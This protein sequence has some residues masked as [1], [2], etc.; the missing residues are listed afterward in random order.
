MTENS[1]DECSIVASLALKRQRETT[2]A[3]GAR[4]YFLAIPQLMAL[5]SLS[6]PCVEESHVSTSFYVPDTPQNCSQASSETTKEKEVTVSAF[7]S[8]AM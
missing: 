5:S 6:T 2:K 1:V 8:L 7:M 4:Y 3:R